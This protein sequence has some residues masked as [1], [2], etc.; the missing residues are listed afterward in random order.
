MKLL[1]LI[2]IN[3]TKKS[4]QYVDPGVVNT[5]YRASLD[6]LLQQLYG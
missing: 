4:R 1:R 3:P 6:M 2:T 5:K